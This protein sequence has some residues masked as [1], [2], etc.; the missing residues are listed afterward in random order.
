EGTEVVTSTLSAP[1]PGLLLKTSAEL[2][3]ELVTPVEE[4]PKAGNQ[5]GFEEAAKRDSAEAS[6]AEQ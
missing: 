2:E 4:G 1:L 6:G 3:T 5:A